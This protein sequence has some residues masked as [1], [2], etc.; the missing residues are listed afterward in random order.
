MLGC[1]PARAPTPTI[2]P[3]QAGAPAPASAPSGPVLAPAS[4]PT[5]EPVA[6]G[7]N[8]YATALDCAPPGVH[9]QL[10][11]RVEHLLGWFTESEAAR[12]SRI[13]LR[14]TA[15]VAARRPMAM[16]EMDRVVRELLPL[17][18]Q[19]SGRAAGAARLRRLPRLRNPATLAAAIAAIDRIWTAS[20]DAPRHSLFDVSQYLSDFEN[21][22]TSETEVDC[23]EMGGIFFP[24]S[25]VVEQALE[26]G[27]PR[28]KVVQ[29]LLA[30]TRDMANAGRAAAR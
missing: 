5:S 18:L 25:N 15:R 6:E 11:V 12:L 9:I 17:L 23:L 28:E 29:A 4:E 24:E 14:G 21:H 20:D 2:A 16:V 26:S 3:A 7:W 10:H 19:A 8:G 22:V 30:M 27:A 1:A 13:D